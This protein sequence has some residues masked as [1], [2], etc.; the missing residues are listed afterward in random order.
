[1][2]SPVHW[3]FSRI[4][5][6]LTVIAVVGTFATIATSQVNGGIPIILDEYGCLNPSSDLPSYGCAT[7]STGC[8]FQDLQAQCDALAAGFGFAQGVLQPSISR[9]TRCFEPGYQYW[10]CAGVGSSCGAPNS[11]NATCI[12]T[13]P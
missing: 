10:M 1:M 7:N 4:A 12:S 3:K 8:T 2:P 9:F 6:V 11:T 13:I 5:T